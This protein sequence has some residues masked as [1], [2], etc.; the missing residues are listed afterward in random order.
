MSIF[1]ETFSFS[2]NCFNT[3]LLISSSYSPVLRIIFFICLEFLLNSRSNCFSFLISSLILRLMRFIVLFLFL[4]MSIFSFSIAPICL[5]VLFLIL[6]IILLFNFLRSLIVERTTLFSR[7]L[8]SSCFIIPCNCDT[9][10][11]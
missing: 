11:L 3:S 8:R 1:N 10:D 5:R 6:R 2:I 4:T 9:R 7:W